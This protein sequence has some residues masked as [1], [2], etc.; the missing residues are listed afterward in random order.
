MIKK[1]VDI[2]YMVQRKRSQR[3]RSQRK[4]S[5]R[6]KSLKRK[7]VGGYDL[8]VVVLT[9]WTEEELRIIAEK[10]LKDG[11]QI[12]NVKTS[13][14]NVKDYLRAVLMNFVN[15]ITKRHD[16]RVQKAKDDGSYDKQAKRFGEQAVKDELEW[17]EWWS[18]N[19]KKNPLM[20]HEHIEKL[21]KGSFITGTIAALGAI[22]AYKSGN[23]KAKSLAGIPA[24]MA[25]IALSLGAGI[26]H[27]S[28]KRDKQG[29]LFVK[30]IANVWNNSN[31]KAGDESKRYV[32]KKEIMET[33]LEISN[34][35]SDKDVKKM[36]KELEK[37]V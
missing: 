19:F 11:K 33:L 18:E 15:F 29:K 23:T 9:G 5:Q 10:T 2:S 12:G 6:K 36:N 17:E 34:E 7:Q 24:V 35:T 8:W 26:M 16:A 25:G 37:V 3:K 14:T 27:G 32:T 31:L 4:R 20:R 21:K 22:A 28:R 30:V 13:Y 1:K